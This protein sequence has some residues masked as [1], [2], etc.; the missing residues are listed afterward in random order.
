MINSTK[1]CLAATNPQSHKDAI[2]CETALFSEGDEYTYHTHPVGVLYPSK[3]DIETTAKFKKK[4]LMIGIVPKNEVVVW[5]PYPT[6]NRMV[7]RFKV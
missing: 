4:L 6:Y 5:A 3:Q 1:H 7:G 2:K